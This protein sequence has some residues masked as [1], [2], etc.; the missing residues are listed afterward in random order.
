[1]P[2]LIDDIALVSEK[3]TCKACI[4]YAVTKV[5]EDTRPRQLRKWDTNH[6][7]LSEQYIHYL[8][9]IIVRKPLDWCA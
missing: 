8:S 6:P 7:T 2:M 3:L 5:T 9:D 1:M 4:T